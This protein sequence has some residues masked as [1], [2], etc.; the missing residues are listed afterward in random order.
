[1]LLRW[2]KEEAFW[3]DVARSVVSGLILAPLL[4]LTA[5]LLGVLDDPDLWEFA[6]LVVAY[7]TLPYALVAWFIVEK[8]KV[9]ISRRAGVA[10]AVSLFLLA[11][12]LTAGGLTL[13]VSN[14]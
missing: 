8:T 9:N 10:V 11:I 7:L 1:M 5:G 3:R 12:F 4:V 6:I 2:L 14:F 13:F